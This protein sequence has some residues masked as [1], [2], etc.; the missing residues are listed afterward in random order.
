MT[1]CSNKMRKINWQKC[2]GGAYNATTPR[3]KGVHSKNLIYGVETMERNMMEQHR[4]DEKMLLL[5]VVALMIIALVGL[6]FGIAKN[7][8]ILALVSGSAFSAAFK[9]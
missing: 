4:H 3:G 6:V 1:K 8:E 9:M 7:N 5:Q 2:L